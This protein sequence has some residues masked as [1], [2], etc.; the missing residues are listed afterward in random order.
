MIDA[1]K[2]QVNNLVRCLVSNDAGIYRVIIPF[3]GW[4]K[5]RHTDDFERMLRI[6]RC[7]SNQ[8]GAPYPVSKIAGVK[9][10]EELLKKMPDCKK[11]SLASGSP[12]YEIE[13]N[14]LGKAKLPLSIVPYGNSKFYVA[15][16]FP[17]GNM[18][19]KFIHEIQNLFALHVGYDL[20]IDL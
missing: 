6:D 15:G 7:T 10:T 11:V 17:Y 18:Q 9:I 13:L 3:C 16:L 14:P 12:L 19:Y 4:Q 5:K 20:K 2:L 8:F 1:T